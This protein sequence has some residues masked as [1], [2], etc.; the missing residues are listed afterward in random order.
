MLIFLCFG[1][2]FWALN[3]SHLDG[4]SIAS[5]LEYSGSAM[6]T[7]GF[8]APHGLVRQLLAFAAAGVGLT[9]LAL[10]IAYIPTLYGAFSRREALITK[11]VVRSGVPPSGPAL[12]ARTWELGRFEQL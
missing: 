12:L 7:L 1:G 9:L 5:A 6:F 8:D 10:V 3:A 2:L 11:L 4:A